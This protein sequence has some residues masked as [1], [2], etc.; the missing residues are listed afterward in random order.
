MKNLMRTLFAGLSILAMGSA[1]NASEAHGKIEAIRFDTLFL[2]ATVHLFFGTPTTC[3]DDGWYVYTYA[4]SGLRKLWTEAI[5]EAYI[6]E[7]AVKVVGDDQCDRLA[8]EGVLFVELQQPNPGGGRG[9]SG[10]NSFGGK[11]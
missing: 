11:D 1:A 4:D 2:P 5:L 7:K 9:T 8:N 6:N 10:G 3:T